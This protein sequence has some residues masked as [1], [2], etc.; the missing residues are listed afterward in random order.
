MDNRKWQAAA[1]VSAPSPEASPSVGHPTDGDPSSAVPA[2]IPGA[3]WFYQV[4]E[5][6]RKVITDAGL[7]PDD[8]DLTQLSDSIQALISASQVP[9]GQ[10]MYFA[11]NTAPTG[12]LKANGAAVSRATYAALF[13]AIG[14]TFGAG[15]GSTTFNLPDLRGEFMRGW[16]DS[17]GTDSG[18]VFGSAQAGT[19]IGG[20]GLESTADASYARQFPRISDSDA[21]TTVA[22]NR[23]LIAIGSATTEAHNYAMARVRPNNVAL[24]A[25]IKF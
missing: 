20:S 14:T 24:L 9:A 15:D 25:C 18:R 21:S 23:S 8:A 1:S 3:Y 6:I 22:G 5:E 10:V 16:D 19:R 2:T 11:K 7:T 17:R 12:Y 4:G 13:A